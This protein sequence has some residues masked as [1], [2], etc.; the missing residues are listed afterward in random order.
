ME[1]LQGR[2]VLFLHPHSVIQKE[3]I[4]LLI[5]AEYEVALLNDRTSVPRVLEKLPNAILFINIDEGLKEAEWENYIRRMLASE[6]TRN[7]GVGILSYNESPEL[8]QKYLM[9]IGV[10][11]GFVTLKLGLRESARIILK[12][13]EANEARGRRQYVRVACDPSVGATFNFKLAN[14]YVTGRIL[15]ISSAGMACTF[16]KD[17][18]L[19]PGDPL[20]DMQLKFR[21]VLCR[22][23]GRLIGFRSGNN[24]KRYV[25]MF[26]KDINQREKQKIH[27]F[28]YRRIQEDTAPL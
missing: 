22:A 4:Q 11:C 13:L 25:V 24:P 17:V 8:A 21:A 26:D 1:E 15:D 23:S 28:V 3:M 9:D 2:R 5:A 7:V 19:S 18:P 27:E 12:T 14:E 6:K 16:D 10:P 20:A